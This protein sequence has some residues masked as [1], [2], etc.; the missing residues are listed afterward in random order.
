LI[1]LLELANL[2]NYEYIGISDHTQ[3][4][5]GLTED[6]IIEQHK[7]IDELNKKSNCKILKSAECEMLSDGKLDFSTKILE[8]LDY[9]IIAIHTDIS[10]SCIVLYKD[11]VFLSRHKGEDYTFPPL[12]YTVHLQP[13]TKFL[14][15]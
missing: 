8:N 1:G 4:M 15:T 11:R 2:L 13:H 7:I 9:R 6:S 12:P 14:F 5:N 10:F 3:I